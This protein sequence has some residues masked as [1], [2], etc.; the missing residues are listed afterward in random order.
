MLLSNQA[1]GLARGA[2]AAAAPTGLNTCALEEISKRNL[3]V[4]QQPEYPVHYS[5]VDVIT[6]E[7]NAWFSYS[8]TNDFSL[9][10]LSKQ[11]FEETYAI[12]A[13]PPHRTVESLD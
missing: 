3:T 11:T 4:T 8:L 12:L 7:L 1:V 13:L 6:T 2:V 10:L 9:L 5:S